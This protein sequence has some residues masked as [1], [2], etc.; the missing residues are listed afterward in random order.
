MENKPTL[1]DLAPFV[2]IGLF[3]LGGYLAGNGH[4]NA[5]VNYIQTDPELIAAITLA[6]PSAWYAIAKWFDWKR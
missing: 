3:I 1:N 4:S 5:F 2:R 6:I